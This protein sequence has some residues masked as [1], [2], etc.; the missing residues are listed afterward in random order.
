[1]SEL[2]VPADLTRFFTPEGRLHQVPRKQEPR[3]AL[4]RWLAG[5]VPSGQ[6]LTETEVNAALRPVHDDV[7][8]LRRYLVDHG[9]LE[10]PGGVYRRP[11]GPGEG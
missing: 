9:L 5:L 11:A 10:R 6:D 7:A 8:M 3:L 1:M 2:Q 4:L